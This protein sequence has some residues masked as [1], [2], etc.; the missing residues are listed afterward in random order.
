LGR[1]V[2]KT[3]KNVFRLK[4]RIIPKNFL[5]G[6]SIGKQLENI[7]DPN[8]HA[9]NTGTASALLRIHGDSVPIVHS[10]QLN[11]DRPLRQELTA[12][13]SSSKLNLGTR[14]AEVSRGGLQRTEEGEEKRKQK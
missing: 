5:F 4:I 6:R 13:F 12:F 14:E 7:Y 8:A 9:S 3:G 11:S 1:G 10:G 2:L